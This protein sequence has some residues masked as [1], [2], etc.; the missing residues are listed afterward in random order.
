MARRP[1][2][3][4]FLMPAQC[5]ALE[6]VASDNRLDLGLL[7]GRNRINAFSQYP[8]GLQTLLPSIYET[9]NGRVVKRGQPLAPI[10]FHI[11][12]APA[13]AAIGVNEEVKTVPIEKL[14][15]AV[16]RLCRAA[17]GVSKGS[18]ST[19]QKVNPFVESTLSQT[20]PLNRLTA[21]GFR[22]NVITKK[23]ARR[24]VLRGFQRFWWP[25]L[26]P[27]L[28][29]ETGI[30]PATFALRVRCSTD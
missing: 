30:E 6:C 17:C 8:L 12:E 15:W 5:N 10:Q 25:S 27:E 13:F 26:E 4:H 2:H 1:L 19:S 7:P 18:S 28:V 29:P 9:D 14:V 22:R 16:S 23:P 11:P 20:L 24:R 21:V 3:R